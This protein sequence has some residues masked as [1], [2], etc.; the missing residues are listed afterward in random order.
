MLYKVPATREVLGSLPNVFSA[1]CLNQ[2]GLES[3]VKRRPFERL[4]KVL[5]SPVYLSAMRRRRSADPLGDTAS[6]LGNAMDEL[7]RHQPSLKVDAIA[8]IIKVLYKLHFLITN[9]L[10]HMYFSNPYFLFFLF[11]IASYLKNCV[12]WAVIRDTY[13]GV[14]LVNLKIHLQTRPLEIVKHLVN[15]LASESEIPVV[16]AEA[17]VAAVAMKKKKTRRKQARVRI[18]NEKSNL[19]CPR[20][21]L[22]RHLN[23]EKRPPLL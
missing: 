8:A 18:L 21:S 5:L 15:Q 1:L 11:L 16:A 10:L 7:M 9:F 19:V 12:Y 20:H 6:N 14:P 17:A 22:D 13:A 23:Q 2:R 4:F 3:F